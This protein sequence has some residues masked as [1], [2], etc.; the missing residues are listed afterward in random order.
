MPISLANAQY[1]RLLRALAI[2]AEIDSTLAESGDERYRPTAVAS[3]T[4]LEHLLTVAAN[5]E[6]TSVEPWEGKN[7]LDK[8]FLDGVRADLGVYDDY[9]FWDE[10]ALRLAERE[11]ERR[12][13]DSA[14]P[15]EEFDERLQ[16]LQDKYWRLLRA[17]GL[18]ALEV[19][20]V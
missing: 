20:L 1:S 8:E 5:H 9:V 12:E 2:A 18:D 6:F 19:R 17:R 11:L 15:D 7:A 14:V 4:L 3:N 10:L 16:A 13:G